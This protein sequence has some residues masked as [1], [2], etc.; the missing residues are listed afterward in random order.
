MYFYLAPAIPLVNFYYQSAQI[1][2]L[3]G[4]V[5]LHTI[6]QSKASPGSTHCIYNGVRQTILT[7]FLSQRYFWN[8]WTIALCFV[9]I[10]SL[11]Y[12]KDL[13]SYTTCLNHNIFWLSNRVEIMTLNMK[14][15]LCL[16]IIILFEQIKIFNSDIYLQCNFTNIC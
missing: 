16:K 11:V 13:S 3:L 6:W 8:I 10:F 14:I 1:C 5:I 12:N 2:P 9:F 7:K 4:M 15:I